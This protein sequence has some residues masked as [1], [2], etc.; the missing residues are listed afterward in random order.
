MCNIAKGVISNQTTGHTIRA[1][2]E[3]FRFQGFAD[4]FQALDSFKAFLQSQNAE[5]ICELAAPITVQL[6]P[7]EILALSGTNTLYTN[8]GDTT[9]VGRADPNAT[10][11]GL[12]SR[13]DALEKAVIGGV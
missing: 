6:T 12:L 3:V 7:Q 1:N 4:T 10:I 13:I 11:K 2:Y 8:T 5:I 9:V